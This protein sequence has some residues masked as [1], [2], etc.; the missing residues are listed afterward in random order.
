LAICAALAAF[1]VL[2]EES[3]SQPSVRVFNSSPDRVRVA[4]DANGGDFYMETNS[5]GAVEGYGCNTESGAWVDCL[6][7]GSC[8]GENPNQQRAAGQARRLPEGRPSAKLPR[9]RQ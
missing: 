9:P 5:S 8:I 4:C 7:N 6:E 1:P 2:A 3:R